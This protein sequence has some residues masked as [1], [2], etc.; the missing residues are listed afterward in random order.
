MQQALGIVAVCVDISRD[1]VDIVSRAE[2]LLL[3]ADFGRVQ[4]D[5]LLFNQL[6]GGHLIHRLNVQAE[7]RAGWQS[8]QFAQQLFAQARRLNL[9]VRRGAIR[10][11]DLKRAGRREIKAAGRDEVFGGQSGF[12]QPRPL[13]D[14]RR[15]VVHV[16]QRVQQGKSLFA[17]HQHGL[18]ADLLEIALHIQSDTRQPRP[19]TLDA[20]GFDAEGHQLDAR[21]S[22]VAAHVLCLQQLNVFCAER[23]IGLV[24]FQHGKR[25]RKRFRVVLAVDAGHL[26][27]HSAVKVAVKTAPAAE[28]TELF[29]FIL[30][31]VVHIVKEQRHGVIVFRHAAKP[32]LVHAQIR[33]R[34]LCAAGVPA[35]RFRLTGQLFELLF[36]RPR[37][38]NAGLF[39]PVLQAPSPLF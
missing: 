20:F 13:K 21:L 31:V 37:Q 18:H 10:F 26:H 1:D 38:L 7:H 25:T 4:H 29:R 35:V 39:S 17:V 34:L 14:K 5:L 19:R 28:N 32:V 2:R 9:D 15:M 36:L 12:R 11:P 3:F 22:V 24:A 23:T 27:M 30:K 16:K 8:E 6:D 33:N